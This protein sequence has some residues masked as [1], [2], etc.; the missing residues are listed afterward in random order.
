MNLVGQDYRKY[1]HETKDRD[2]IIL[3]PPW[4]YNDN[5]NPSILDNQVNY[6]RWSDNVKC[7]EEIFKICN[8]SYLF[9]WTTNSLLK[10][11][12]SCNTND[13]IFKSIITWVKKTSQNNTHYG[14]GSYFRNSTEQLLVFVK[15]GCKPLRSAK[16]NLIEEYGGKRTRKPKFFETQLFL[17]LEQ[18][19]YR[20]GAYIFSGEEDI[21]FEP[22]DIDLVDI[23]FSLERQV[24]FQNKYQKA[25]DRPYSSLQEMVKNNLE[26]IDRNVIELFR[27]GY[28]PIQI[29]NAF[30]KDI[31]EI[32][33][34]LTTFYNKPL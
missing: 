23:C 9:L 30:N 11:V 24:S 17:E 34:I 26:Y 33:N 5:E 21:A 22:F 10:E 18:K 14:L 7:V 29:A 28:R 4:S 25:K 13:Y 27:T 12:L 8:C 3:D 6:F 19:G 2:Y 16:R 15:K 20:K 1:L 31:D 32:N